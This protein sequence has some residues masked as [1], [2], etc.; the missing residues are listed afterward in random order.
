MAIARG[1]QRIGICGSGR[2]RPLGLYFLASGKSFR[3]TAG[4][5]S[6]A[7]SPTRR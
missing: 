2:G 3:E 7:P 4:S 1:V 6:S 5:R